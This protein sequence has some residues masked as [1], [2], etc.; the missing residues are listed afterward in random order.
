[1]P[2][3]RRDDVGLAGEVELGV[4]AERTRE[5]R[6]LK[7]LV[8]YWKEQAGK[9]TMKIWKKFRMSVKD[10]GDGRHSI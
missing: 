7:K 8:A 10:R 6:R 5:I 2:R 9:K 1:M 4:V 3:R